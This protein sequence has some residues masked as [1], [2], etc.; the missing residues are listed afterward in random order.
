[1]RFAATLRIHNADESIPAACFIKG[2]QALTSTTPNPPQDAMAALSKLDDVHFA[3]V[4]KKAE[5]PP[6][7]ESD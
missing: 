2:G 7:P 1:M 6:D 4:C 3:Y 5:R